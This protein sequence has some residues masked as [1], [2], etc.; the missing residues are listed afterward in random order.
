MVLE[1]F[2]KYWDSILVVVLFVLACIIL[3]RR[4]AT[5]YVKQML[6]YLVI[7]AE[8]MYGGGTGDLKYA[9]VTTWLYEHMPVVLKIFFTAKQV[10][11]L[12]EAAVAKMK[13]YLSSNTYAQAL[14]STPTQS[15]DI[16]I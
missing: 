9:A 15:P 12:I 4:G 13:E 14:V 6:F 5:A 10:D 8:S 1:F 7:T 16:A 3:I 11:I 2:A